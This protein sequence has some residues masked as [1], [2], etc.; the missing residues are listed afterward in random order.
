VLITV[1]STIKK[2]KTKMESQKR[3]NGMN[4]FFS[5]IAVVLS[6]FACLIGG[7]TLYKVASLEQKVE[8]LSQT[9]ANSEKAQTSLSQNSTPENTPSQSTVP[10]PSDSPVP[11]VNNTGI[12]PSQFVQ[13]AFGNKAQIELLAV[14]RI[15][16]PETGT[17][18]VVNVQF[19]AR[20][21]VRDEENA[22]YGLISADKTTARNP[23]TSE[24]YQSIS[25]KRS[26]GYVELNYV[27]R[28]ASVDAYVWLKVPEATS[29]LD[30]YVPQTQVFK[31]VPIAS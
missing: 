8:T 17:R 5:S 31:N 23:D 22:P 30:I 12:Q 13:F 25:S 3:N 21:L 20:R 24:T 6:T 4:N 10:T 16:D 26:T 1:V 19:R 2:K 15:K 29:T 7:F 18:D 9:V 28:G 11:P 27:K 14:K